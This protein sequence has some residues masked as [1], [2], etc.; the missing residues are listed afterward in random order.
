MYINLN[1]MSGVL[2]FSIHIVAR[3][4]LTIISGVRCIRLMSFYHNPRNN[5]NICI[6]ILV[7]VTKNFYSNRSFGNS[8]FGKFTCFMLV[9]LTVSVCKSRNNMWGFLFNDSLLVTF[10]WFN[11]IGIYVLCI[12]AFLYNVFFLCTIKHEILF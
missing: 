11:L 9:L 12:I 5:P 8:Y 10:Y 2:E 4:K 7:F 1:A 3:T 6:Y